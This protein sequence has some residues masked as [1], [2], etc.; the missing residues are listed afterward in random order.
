MEDHRLRVWHS[1]SEMCSNS[2]GR[3]CQLQSS[4]A[5]AVVCQQVMKQSPCCIVTASCSPHPF[6]THSHQQQLTC[7]TRVRLS[8][9]IT[10]DLPTLG[11]PT[12]PTVIAV[13]M[14]ALRA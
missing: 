1:S 2:K 13:L 14:S 3:A 8:E 5:A 6:L 11:S 10:L 4:K 12:T 7:A 9:L